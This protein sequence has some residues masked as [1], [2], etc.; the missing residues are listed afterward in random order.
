MRSL[1]VGGPLDGSVEDSPEHPEVRIL[2]DAKQQPHRYR[3]FCWGTEA[4]D[5]RPSKRVYNVYYWDGMNPDDRAA[6]LKPH[7]SKLFD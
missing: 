7:I 2:Q 3:L 5:N 4:V 1:F 6:A